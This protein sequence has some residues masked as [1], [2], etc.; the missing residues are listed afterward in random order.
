MNITFVVPRFYPYPGGYENYV[1][2]LARGLIRAG[3][4]VT[5]L[6]TNAFD[7][8]YFWMKGFR[9]LPAGRE[10]HEGIEILRLPICHRRWLR[11]A[12]RLLGLLPLWELKARFAPPSFRVIGIRD[13][14]KRVSADVIHVGPLPYNQLMYEGF[15][16]ARRRGIR[17]VVTP[18]TH[19]G[20]ERNDEVSRYYTQ[21]FQMTLLKQC[22]NTFALTRAE[23]QSLIHLGIPPEKVAVTS[24][25][26]DPSEV[27]GGEAE[28]FC[29]KYG[30]RGPVVLHLGMKAPD[31][32]SICVVEAMKCLWSTGIQAW[33]VLAGPSLRS[34]DEYLQNQD[35]KLPRLLNLG[36]V[37]EREKKDA[38]AAASVVVQPSR[39]ESLG[40]VYLEA[41]ANAKPVIAADM[42]VTRELITSSCDGLLVPFGEPDTLAAAIRHVLD[43]PSESEKMGL[44]GQQKV[45]S[46]YFYEAVAN[47]MFPYFVPRSTP[48]EET[49]GK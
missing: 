46:Q 1:L 12:S 33:L 8:E 47:K 25:G 18:C 24:A 29:T 23:R 38:L 7:L 13:A 6:T 35:S 9:S 37:S 4:T 49:G 22:D 15:R 16:E 19:F 43:D 11:R 45:R 36:L 28:A 30:I 44:R 10:T 26:I 48:V 34:F 2:G 40:L 14:L 5:V 32:G 20:E 42:A 27:T 39:V 17:V 21:E 31:K 41:W 3:N